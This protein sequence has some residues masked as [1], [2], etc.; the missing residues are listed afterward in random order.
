MVIHR[1]PVAPYIQGFAKSRISFPAE[2][3]LLTCQ[4]EGRLF[5]CEFKESG[6]TGV[7]ESGGG[8]VKARRRPSRRSVRLWNRATRD[9]SPA[10]RCTFGFCRDALEHIL[11]CPH[12]CPH[13]GEFKKSGVTG[14]Q[15]SGGCR[16]KARRRPSRRSVPL[17]N[18]ATRDGSPASQVHRCPRAPAYL[19]CPHSGRI[20]EVRSCRSSGGRRHVGGRVGEASRF[21]S[22]QNRDGSPAS[23]CAGGFRRDALL[24]APVQPI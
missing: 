22:E 1:P 7:Q 5:G 9:G 21:G 2:S 10:S 13:L 20:Q 19:T 16:V 24:R 15:E 17:R 23:Q 8:G 11:T 6:V 18:R 3:G 14:V 12:L 4:L